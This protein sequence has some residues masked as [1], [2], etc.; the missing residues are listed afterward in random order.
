MTGPCGSGA[1]A[2]G[3]PG[4]GTVGEGVLGCVDAVGPVTAVA[5]GDDLGRLAGY[6]SCRDLCWPVGFHGL[7]RVVVVGLVV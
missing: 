3:C 2:C 7:S 6:V 1:T 5:V 4:L